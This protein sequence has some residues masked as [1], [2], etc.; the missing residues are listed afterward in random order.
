MKINIS[1]EYSIGDTVYLCT[2]AEQ[3]KR[4]V[5]GYVVDGGG[6]KYI[7]ASS[8]IISEHYACEMSNKKELQL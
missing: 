1:V 5:T 6:V 7:L 3:Y 2:D 8:E 4:I